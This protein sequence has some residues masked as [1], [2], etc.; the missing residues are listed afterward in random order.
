VRSRWVPL[1]VLLAGC[2]HAQEF[3]Y[4]YYGVIPS[5]GKL[6][7]HEE[8]QDKPLAICEP[9]DQV[10]GKCA[11]FE[12]LVLERLRSDMIHLKHELRALQEATHP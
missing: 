10:K 2:A 5:Q 12:N 1:A 7:G 11:V 8:S 9:D 4:P 6:L 3:P